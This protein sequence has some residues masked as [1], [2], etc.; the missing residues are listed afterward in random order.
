MESKHP[1]TARAMGTKGSEALEKALH[2]LRHVSCALKSERLCWSEGRKLMRT[3]KEGRREAFVSSH[4]R[5]KG[6]IL[7]SEAILLLSTPKRD[8]L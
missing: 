6:E 1:D 8:Y 5:C 2:T 4:G 7:V 3:G